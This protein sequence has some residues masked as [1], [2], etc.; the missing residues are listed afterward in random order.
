MS[1]KITKCQ[2][3]DIWENPKFYDNFKNA[4]ILNE[5]EEEKCANCLQRIK[6]I[7]LDERGEQ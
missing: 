6:R 1:V 3:C 5:Y 2:F 4:V 7:M